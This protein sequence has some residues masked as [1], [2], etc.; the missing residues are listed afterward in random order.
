M[1]TL[2]S[3]MKPRDTDLGTN[4]SGVSEVSTHLR[5]SGRANIPLNGGNIV[6]RCELSPDDISTWPSLDV[7]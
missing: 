5:A 2:A 6:A 1:R 4:V 3:R 7:L